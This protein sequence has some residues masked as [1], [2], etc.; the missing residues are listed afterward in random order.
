VTEGRTL[1]SVH[2]HTGAVRSTPNTS[3][4][5]ISSNEIPVLERIELPVNKTLN[6]AN[7]EVDRRGGAIE[8]QINDALG[9]LLNEMSEQ[10]QATAG[11]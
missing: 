5:A 8:R 2:Q 7:E 11:G 9:C 10:R 3:K 4:Y 6:R 1:V